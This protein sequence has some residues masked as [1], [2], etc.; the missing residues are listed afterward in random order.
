MPLSELS[1]L[2]TSVIRKLSEQF[3]LN[4]SPL[5]DENGKIIYTSEQR[6]QV[7]TLYLEVMILAFRHLMVNV[8][9]PGAEKSMLDTFFTICHG[10]QEEAVRLMSTLFNDEG[11]NINLMVW[12]ALGDTRDA[13]TRIFAQV[14]QELSEQ[15]PVDYTPTI[16]ENKSSEIDGVQHTGKHK[17]H[18]GDNI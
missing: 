14:F 16:P 7:V 18:P 8:Y 13:V 12:E 4:A 15:L 3:A 9:T 1:E 11:H 6:C 17:D 2:T 5:T 10:N